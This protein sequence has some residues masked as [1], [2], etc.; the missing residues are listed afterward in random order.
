MCRA[1]QGAASGQ[2]SNKCA[3]MGTQDQ[4]QRGPDKHVPPSGDVHVRSRPHTWAGV[5]GM[6][7]R[8]C[9]LNAQVES[10]SV[11]ILGNL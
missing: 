9:L 3:V 5:M 10:N 11:L 6:Q 8:A 4:P 2:H 7:D 1:S